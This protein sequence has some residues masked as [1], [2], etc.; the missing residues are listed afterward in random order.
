M[1]KIRAAYLFDL[2]AV[3]H[4]PPHMIGALRLTDFARL[5][6]GIDQMAARHQNGG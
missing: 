1:R 5:V 2:A 6:T 3:C 4:V